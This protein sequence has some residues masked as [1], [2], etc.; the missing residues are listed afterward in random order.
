M[1]SA[2]SR[3][4]APGATP[5]VVVDGLGGSGKT[6]LATQWAH[7][8]IDR[9]PDGQL[10]ADLRGHSPSGAADPAFVLE[11]LVHA[12]GGG[13]AATDDTERLS[14][15][16]RSLLAGRRMIVILDDARDAEQVRPLL[17]A[18][19]GSYVLV[20]SRTRLPELS[21][22]PGAHRLS[23]KPM[24]DD[25]GVALLQQLTGDAASADPA[26]AIR[27]V[28]LCGGLP[29]ALRLAA[30]VLDGGETLGALCLRLTPQGTR[31]ASLDEA[32]GPAAA[33]RLHAA[34]T[35]SCRALP[36]A[37]LPVLHSLLAHPD[38]E[39]SA[40]VAAALAG[41]G[42]AAL[43]ELD[44]LERLNLIE[45]VGMHRYGLHELIR[46]CLA[47]DGVSADAGARARAFS[48]YLHT[49]AAASEV[50]LPERGT[51][52]TP[53]LADGVRAKE[54]KS[55]DGAEAWYAEELTNL[56]AVTRA[57]LDSGDFH[58]ATALPNVALSYLNLRK[59]W[60][61]WLAMFHLAVDAAERASDQLALA[62]SLNAL[63]IAYREMRQY[64]AA[65][66]HLRRAADAYVAAGEPT[67]A[68]MALNNLAN[69]LGDEGQLGESVVILDR[70]L[71][72]LGDRHDPWR[73]SILLNNLADT[74]A[75]AGQSEL[76]LAYGERALE[77]CRE[78]EDV[79]GEAC[80]LTALGKAYAHDSDFARAA[81]YF[82]SAVDRS[83]A[84]KDHY[85]RA[86]T[87]RH[88]ADSLRKL[89]DTAGAR[90]AAISALMVF[91]E[92]ADPAVEDVR[93]LVA[94][95]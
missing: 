23:V 69:L 13:H 34:L 49:A 8:A 58:I 20:T 59:P 73:R 7:G 17:P 56:L 32:L 37:T 81:E 19:A 39:F 16:F 79:A 24:T 60:Q 5:V 29:L 67:G 50:L 53:A 72:H 65:D 74:H 2:L 52:P 12:L 85:N 70:A 61:A 21:V 40:D 36:E 87:E 33:G 66:Q 31:I 75:K 77:L 15:Q 82:R 44:E 18:S 9:Y 86:R 14:G 64:R 94:D 41:R 11:G 80:A 63:G 46:A 78:L 91:E 76:A 30:Q 26:G 42:N 1:L 62:G 55:F 10:Y 38:G 28:S 90:A 35:A 54:F 88:L 93:Q 71:E 45:R 57:A 43:P 47:A 4:Q 27:L 22:D 51:I 48:W 68:A 3:T 84:A 89:G 25:E 95:L 92:I 83:L 6:S